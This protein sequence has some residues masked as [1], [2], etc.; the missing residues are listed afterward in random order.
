M[1]DLRVT[2]GV[3]PLST[4]PAGGEARRHG[5]QQPQRDGR[6]PGHPGAEEL[7][8]A[9]HGAGHGS[10]TARFE[11]DGEGAPMVRI[12]E[13]ESGETIAL[14][15]PEELRDMAEATGLPA[16]LLVQLAS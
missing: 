1:D 11:Q 14:L 10:L 12:V 15:T 13:R 16:G 4:Q 8:V 3:Q 9:L 5:G 6:R 2:Q 7:S